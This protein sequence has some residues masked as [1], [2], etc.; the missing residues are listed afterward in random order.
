MCHGNIYKLIIAFLIIPT[1]S[2][3]LFSQPSLNYKPVITSLT[4]PLDIVSPNDGS[5]RLFIVHKEGKI[6]VYDQSFTYKGDFLTVTG[7]TLQSERGLL[8]MAF[9]PDYK[10]N[11]LFFVYYTNAQG[12]I[13]IARYKVSSNPDIADPVTKSII[14]TIP[15]P[16]AANH[17]GGKLNFG[18]D[19]YLY[20]GTGDGGN[21]GDPP[22]NAQNTGLLLGKMIRID[23][24][25]ATAPLNYSIPADNPY[26]N[27]PAIADE[28]WAIG[29]R[30]PWRWSFDRRSHDMWI[31][32]VGQNAREEINFRKAGETKGLNYG[33]RCYEGKIEYASGRCQLVDHVVPIFDYPHN[34]TTGGFSVTGGFVYRGSE[35]PS[36]NGYYIF[37]DYVSGNQWMI[38][39]SSNTWV[40]KKQ[41]GTFPR[42]IT[43]F[44]ESEDGSLYACSLSDG[45][46]YK[47][48][49]VTSVAFQLL[50]FNGIVRN[51]IAGLNWSAT[52]QNLRQYEVESSTDSINFQ[53]KGIVAARNQASENSYSFEEN[54]QGIQKIFYRLRILNNDG[55]WDYSK[56]IAVINNS[57]GKNF[58]YPSWITNKVIN[59]FIPE[60][61]DHLQVFSM[62]G[63]LVLKKDI[64]GIT[65]RIDVTIPTLAKGIYLVQISNGVSNI[66]QRIFVN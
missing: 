36:L 24:N 11:G 6:K 48:E 57:A 7:I 31:A 47:I 53:R 20:F 61:Y 10:S 26:V 2:F 58:I 52:E 25:N 66:K 21:G 23:I 54:M 63:V 45:I 14:I 59:C 17:N 62:N 33:W 12:S 40:I 56:T 41:T 51:N 38:S 1:I 60:P 35:Y 39:D 43:S 30:N 65:G 42:N 3:Q 19:G 44:G 49:A 64:R 29:L 18:A 28:I 55:K 22:N 34:N 27:D 50:N 5:K 15:H 16:G 32:D 13:E 9:H 4:N 46:I 8:S 37:A